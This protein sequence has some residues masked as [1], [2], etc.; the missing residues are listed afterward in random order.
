MYVSGIVR[1]SSSVMVWW[2]DPLTLI[3]FIAVVW[4]WTELIDLQSPI[5]SRQL[6][7]K[8]PNLNSLEGIFSCN[9]HSSTSISQSLISFL[10]L[11]MVC[12]VYVWEWTAMTGKDT[13]VGKSHLLTP[14]LLHIHSLT[15]PVIVPLSVCLLWPTVILTF[16]FTITECVFFLSPPR[17]AMS[18]TH[19]K[20]PSVMLR[21]S[22]FVVGEFFLGSMIVPWI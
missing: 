10:R 20:G 22:R 11:H 17:H 2:E 5:I 18:I 6:H 9:L 1:G 12:C 16:T 21:R 14:L 4:T 8:S 15:F 3:Q 13:G 19:F 7:N